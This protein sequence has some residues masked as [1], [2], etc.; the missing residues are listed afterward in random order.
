MRLC[1]ATVLTAV[2]ATGAS[3][4]TT[5]N[6]SFSLNGG[7]YEGTVRFSGT[8]QNNDGF[9]RS[10]DGEVDDLFGRYSNGNF[11]SPYY[12]G[13]SFDETYSSISYMIDGVFGDNNRDFIRYSHSF[14]TTC[15]PHECGIDRNGNL[16]NITN[17][18]NFYFAGDSAFAEAGDSISIMPRFS[19][20]ANIGPQIVTGPV[21]ALSPVPLPASSF[22]L[23]SGFLG[24]L[25]FRKRRNCLQP[26]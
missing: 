17:Y 18:S 13:I 25:L 15:P 3:A 23:L 8:D 4:A 14:I 2:L 10:A 24:L 1:L 22:A 20:S 11:G 5:G 21:S 19:L 6:W 16:Y 12:A 7:G 9:L 26:S